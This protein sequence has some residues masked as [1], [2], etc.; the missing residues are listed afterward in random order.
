M[1]EIAAVPVKARRWQF[2]VIGILIFL[3]LGTVYSWS[4]FRKPIE[5]IYQINATQSGLPYMFFLFFYA[6]FM[7]LAGGAIDRVSPRLMTLIGGLLVGGGWI[8][9]GF[10]GNILVLILTYGLLAGGGVG[11]T[12]GVPIAVVARWYPDR[13]GF[14]VGL[15][16]LGFG[17]SPFVTAPLA[18]W[19]IGLYGPL[20]TFQL[21]GTGFVIII[22]VLALFLRFPRT[23]GKVS[24]EREVTTGPEIQKPGVSRSTGQDRI[25]RMP[26]FWGLWFCFLIGTVIG[27]MA[28]AI[29]SPVAI[30]VLGLGQGR[31]ALLISMFAVFNGLGRPLYGWLTDRYSPKFAAALSF[32]MIITASLIM[33]TAGKYSVFFY[34]TAFSLL[35]LNL[36][37]WLAIAPAATGVFFGP[38]NYSKNYGFLFTAYGV[39]AIGGTFLSGRLR[40]ILGSYLYVFYPTI[41]LAVLGLVLSCRFLKRPGVEYK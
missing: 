35:W 27:L 21:L 31:A 25:F 2:I 38:E 23:E 36:G 11:I 4:I 13:K 19:L 6:L 10:A 14:V 34:G 26:T 7:P 39:G 12:Y 40:D 20:R 9:A 28:I 5:D 29:S 33:L 3:C 32:L 30:E 41:L 37:G 24:N 22:S 1:L 18:S 17:L 16:L 15:T 8:M